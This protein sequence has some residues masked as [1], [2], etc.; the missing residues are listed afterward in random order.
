M[1]NA[2]V[3]TMMASNV[4]ASLMWRTLAVDVGTVKRVTVIIFGRAHFSGARVWR[5]A[6][7]SNVRKAN[8]RSLGAA[9]L[10]PA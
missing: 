4:I 2:K 8:K 7:V 9:E 10:R 1:N 6:L 3:P 5:G